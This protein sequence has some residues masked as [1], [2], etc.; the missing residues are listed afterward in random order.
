MTRSIRHWATEDIGSSKAECAAKIV[1]ALNPNVKVR[2]FDERLADICRRM[3]EERLDLLIGLHDGAHFIET[4]NPVMVLSGFKSLGAN[5]VLLQR[6]G[7]ME[8]IV[9]PAWDAERAAWMLTSITP[10]SGVTPS[11][12]SR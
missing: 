5:A 11:L 3:R 2:A 12:S 6:D 1:A 7:A 8:I 4:P 9:T 10:G